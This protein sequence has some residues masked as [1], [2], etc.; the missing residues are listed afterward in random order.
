MLHQASESSVAVSCL[1][2][3]P[4]T[5]VHRRPVAEDGHV[6]DKDL[7]HQGNGRKESLVGKTIVLAS[8]GLKESNHAEFVSC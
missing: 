6:S 5:K 1:A 4:R 2:R 7:Q 3:R 8:V